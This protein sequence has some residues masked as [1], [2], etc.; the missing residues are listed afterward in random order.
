MTDPYGILYAEDFDEP[1]PVP[2]PPP[3]V[4]TVAERDQA[5]AEAC[6][7]ATASA[8]MDW[9]QSGQQRRTA[10][11][12]ALADAFGGLQAEIM[13]QQA[14]IAGEAAQSMLAVLAAMLPSLGAQHGPAEVLA[15]LRIVLPRLAGMP[16][17]TVAVAPGTAELVRPDL[18]LFDDPV[19]AALTLVADARLAPGDLRLT[20]PSGS[21]VRDTDTI[22]ADILAAVQAMLP[23]A[24]PPPDTVVPGEPAPVARQQPAPVPVPAAIPVPAT[25]PVP[26]YALAD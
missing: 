24:M 17:I 18:A 22:A 20:W 2:E 10:A 1:E 13:A 3:P 12:T 4:F 9:A 8:R 23:F 11:L 15:L 7:T 21:M 26:F 16:R 6:A 19:A 25:V 14:V 5:V